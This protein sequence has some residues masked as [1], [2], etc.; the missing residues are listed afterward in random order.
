MNNLDACDCNWLTCKVL[1]GSIV[2]SVNLIIILPP[3]CTKRLMEILGAIP[4]TQKRVSVNTWH[5]VLV[6]MWLVV[7]S[8]PGARRLLSQIQ[9]SL[10][11][12]KGKRGSL[13]RGIQDTLK[14][15]IWLTEDLSARLTPILELVPLTPTLTV[16]H[17]ASGYM[18]GGA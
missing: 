2:D 1:L 15:I 12:I 16:N 17:D 3:H 5:Q 14:E 4:P 10:R 8:L 11:H 9:E 18:C 6:E 13:T 7:I